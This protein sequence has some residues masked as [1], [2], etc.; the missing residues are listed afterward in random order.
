MTYNAGMARLAARLLLSVL[1]SGGMAA[2]WAQPAAP[3]HNG[4]PAPSHAQPRSGR[5]RG[6]QTRR[7]ISAREAAREAQRRFGGRVLSVE[8]QRGGGA[9]TYRV[10]LLSGGVVRVVRIPASR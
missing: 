9:P 10:K 4:Q 2:A 3:G 1:L 5:E 8:L 6:A 7:L